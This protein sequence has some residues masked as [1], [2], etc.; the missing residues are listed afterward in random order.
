MES[1]YYTMATELIDAG[2]GDAGRLR[3]ILECI[4]KNK[5]LYKTDMIFLESLSNQL[6]SKLAQL[7]K[8]EHA[9]ETEA[10]GDSSRTLLSDKHLD[11]HLDE[12]DYKRSKNTSKRIAA[13]KKS[14]FKRLFGRRTD[15]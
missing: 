11:E 3:F 1:D 2:I 9:T 7:Q 15:Q 8:P 14:F 10:K 12:M 5:P 13:E 6:D 4:D